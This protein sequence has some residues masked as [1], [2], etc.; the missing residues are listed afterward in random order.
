[1]KHKQINAIMDY[2]ARFHKIMSIDLKIYSTILSRTMRIAAK[3]AFGDR[4]YNSIY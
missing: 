3:M 4:P 2:G 1:M